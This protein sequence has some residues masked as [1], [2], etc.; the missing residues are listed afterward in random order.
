MRRREFIMLIG[1]TAA[2]WPLSAKAQ[3]TTKVP[4]VGFLYPGSATSAVPRIA[5]VTSGLQAGGIRVP[6]Q[7]TIIPSA[8]DG[9][10]ARLAPMAADLIARKAVVIV[11]VGPEA[12]RAASAAST[13]TP[14]V[15]LDLESDPID[16]GFVAS[17]ARPGG[18]ITG[19]FLDFPDFSK[20]WLEALKEAVPKISSVGILWDPSSGMTQRRAIDAAARTLDLKLVV[21]EMRG[22]ADVESVFTTAS[23][24]GLEALVILSSPF[25]SAN[26]KLL[27]DQALLHR[28]P[29]ITLFP[30]F[31]RDGGLMGYGP[32][33]LSYFRHAGILTAGILQGGSPAETPIDRPA[34]FEFV[35][36]LKTAALLGVT[37]SPA[38]LLRA[39]EVIE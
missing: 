22:R 26:T 38:T 9:N 29:A 28:L 19:V 32:N 20:K 12:L 14:I 25:V 11:V 17:Y 6:D 7:A 16:S 15:A 31:A 1:G 39:D 35:L 2:A 24:L 8:T 37:I 3:Q 23:K 5:A 36:N 10:T 30:H 34:K 13:T 27:A 33:L 4:Q 21:L 18:N